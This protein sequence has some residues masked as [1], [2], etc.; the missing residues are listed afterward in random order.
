MSLARSK[1]GTLLFACDC[2]P[3]PRIAIEVGPGRPESE[4]GTKCVRCGRQ[5][6]LHLENLAPGN[7][8]FG[9]LHCGHRELYTRK[10]FPVA[11]GLAIVIAAAVLAPWTRYLSLVA[12]ALLDLVLHRLM[13]DD[14]AC[15]ACGAEHRG[16]SAD[17][18]HPRYD[19]EIAERLR[20]GAR[21]VMGKPM[22]PGGTANAPEPEH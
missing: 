13:P 17:P 19:R 12:A 6:A 15:Y 11:L 9:C 22:R 3:G 10:R 1:P 21:A 16:F 20:F 18:R 2:G 7:G 14:V 8:L 5:H 4:P